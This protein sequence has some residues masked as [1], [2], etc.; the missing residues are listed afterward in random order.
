MLSRFPIPGA[1]AVTWYFGT[2]GSLATSP[3]PTPEVDTFT[4]NPRAVSAV[5][6]AS[7]NA[8]AGGLWGNAADW[9]WDW[10]QNPPGTALSYVTAPLTQNTTAIGAGSVSVWVEASTPNVDLQ[11]TI[12]EVRPDGLETFV[13]DGWVRA[14]ERRL[15]PGSTPLAATLSLRS[16]DVQALPSGVF[17]KV[18]IPLYYEGHAYRAGSRIRVTISAPGGSQPLWAFAKTNPNGT[19]KVSIEM[20][21]NAESSLTLPIVPGVQVPTGLP[22]CPSLR[23]EPCRQYVPFVNQ[24]LGS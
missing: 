21:P 14:D 2:G 13:Q 19:A 16:S 17:T 23:N 11:A 7:G 3:D 1:Q 20:A 10:E 24:T 4:W 8:A 18:T 15:A 6:Y 5:D 12:S 9:D 22:G